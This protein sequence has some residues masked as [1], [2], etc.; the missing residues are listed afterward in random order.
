[1]KIHIL[2]SKGKG[3]ISIPSSKSLT[4]RYCIL[5]SLAHGT[6]I[7]H[8]PLKSDDTKYTLEALKTF[9]VSIEE[10]HN[11]LKITGTNGSYNPI[12]SDIFLGDSGSSARFFIGLSALSNKPVV[13]DGSK[14]LRMRPNKD[15]FRVL[16]EQGARVEFMENDQRLP[17]RIAC[18]KLKGGIMDIS[19]SISSQFISSLLMVSPF[20]QAKSVIRIIDGLKS[21]PYVDLT[22]QAMKKFGINVTNNHYESFEVP[23]NTRYKARQITV[24]GDFSSASYFIVLSFLTDSNIKILNLNKN[25]VQADKKILDY[26]KLLGGSIE[27]HEDSLLIHGTKS[28]K[29]AELDVSDCPDI[30]LSLGI[31]GPFTDNRLILKGTKNLKVKESD[32]GKALVE[33]LRK[34]GS[35]IDLDKDKITI[36][37]S[38]LHSGKIN[39]FGDHRVAMSFSI[40]GTMIPQGIRIDDAHV[41]SKSYPE[42]FSD[43]KKLGL[44]I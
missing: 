3:S 14:R 34:L 25:S 2:P 29:S 1:M 13:I 18:K 43:L 8:N 6:S 10:K 19:G 21:K 32:R 9:G 44:H 22:I 7:I 27:W 42:F 5:A 24:E 35:L 23:N 15:L 4:H 39:T 38:H 33:N 12:K 26:I 37:R 31:V 40:L 36:Y 17:V 11:S 30:A 28:I 20:N 41:V 16:Q